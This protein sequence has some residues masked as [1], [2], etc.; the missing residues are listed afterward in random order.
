MQLAWQTVVAPRDVARLLLALRPGREALLL[1]FA[2]VV[3]LNALIFGL[4]SLTMPMADTGTDEFAMISPT[5]FMLALGAALALTI[6]ALTFA[7][8]AL[9]GTARIEDI[10]L[11]LIWMQGLRVL[12]QI[13]ML[14]LVPLNVSFSM[15]LVVAA[16]ATGVW[17]LVHFLDE[18][19]GFGSLMRGL[20]VML[21]GVAGAALGLA[22][23]L[24]LIGA[25]TMGLNGY[26]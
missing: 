23:L 26:V 18:A 17:I 3:V 22:F 24:S 4:S 8:R 15:L 9:G 10:A 11:L 6:V 21:L 7:G 14:M 16:S 12:V 20:S 13:A 1:G 19:H 2:L 25:T 5:L